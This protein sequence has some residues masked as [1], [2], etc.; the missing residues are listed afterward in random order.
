MSSEIYRTVDAENGGISP[1]SAEQE[2]AFAD[3]TFVIA[4][5]V[6]D[7]GYPPVVNVFAP[8]RLKIGN[9]TDMRSIGIIPAG[10]TGT[11][12]QLAPNADEILQIVEA[13]GQVRRCVWR[14]GRWVCSRLSFTEA[15]AAV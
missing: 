5:K 1:M 13:D 6:R 8:S 14:G 7:A 4:V 11:A 15:V 12:Y 9:T 3:A 10:G 2:A